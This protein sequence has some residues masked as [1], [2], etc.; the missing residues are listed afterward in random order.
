M[1]QLL[2]M[3]AHSVEGEVRGDSEHILEMPFYCKT[4][5]KWQNFVSCDDP[6]DIT[7]DGSRLWAIDRP[8]IAQPL[9]RWQR[10]LRIRG[11][12]GT[13][14][15]DVY[16]ESPS[17]KKLCSSVEIQKYFLFVTPKPLQE[18]YVR[19]HPKNYSKKHPAYL[20]NSADTPRLLAPG[21]EEEDF[22]HCL[23]MRRHVFEHLLHDVQQ[24]N[25]YFQQKRDRA[26]RPNFSPHQ[27]VT[28]ALRMKAYGS[29]ADSMDE[30]HGMS[31]ST[32]LDTLEQFCD[33]ILQVYKDEYLHEPNQ[34]YL[35]RLIRKAVDRGFPS[36]IESLDCMHW[37]WKNCRTRW[38]RGFSG[39]SRKP[40]VHAFF[41]APGSENDI[42]VLGHSPLFNNL[43]EG[44]APQL[45]YYINNR[46]YNMGEPARWWS[47][48]N[49]DSIMMSCIILHNMIME[50]ER[51]GNI[52]GE[53]DDDQEDPNRSRRAR[54]KIYDG[55]NLPFNP[56][57]GKIREDPFC[58]KH[59]WRL[60]VSSWNTMTPDYCHGK[61]NIPLLSEGYQHN[62][63]NP[64]PNKQKY[65]KE[66]VGDEICFIILFLLPPL[67]L[68]AI[69]ARVLPFLTRRYMLLGLFFDEKRGGR[70]SLRRIVPLILF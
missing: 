65:E 35:N 29:P 32:C 45:D 25:P 7:Q 19:K 23:R 2:Q 12:G 55:P 70:P 57:T 54:A 22:K 41:G 3:E 33:T 21:D 14:F 6:E 34:E 48:E 15:A 46:Q 20:T 26:G 9:P 68:A 59:T 8:N 43:M 51:D 44:K 18:N 31:E 42:I 39:R 4:A 17:G 16:Y 66:Q 60:L 63:P 10:L 62:H 52:D 36:M 24:V 67:D 47:R 30:T 53:S 69:A 49:L 37:D 28:I 50:D 56:R 1:C 11:E 38:Q 40:T 5:R 58:K 64:H 27:K 61:L 13:R